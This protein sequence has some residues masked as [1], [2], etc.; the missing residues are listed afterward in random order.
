[1]KILFAL[2]V[3]EVGGVSSVARNLLNCFS[4]EEFGI[5]LLTEKLADAY[6]PI[7]SSIKLIDLNITPKKC[8][9]SKIFNMTRHII[10]IRRHIAKENPDVI[11]GFG[12]YMNCHILLSLLLHTKKRRKVILTEHSEGVFLKIRGNNI[13][14]RHIFFN[15]MYRIVM[16]FLYRRADYIVAVSNSIGFRI[17]RFFLMPSHKVKVIHN[18]VDISRINSLSGEKDS[19]LD[20]NDALPCVG[21]I[22]RLSHEKGIYFLIQGFKILLT[23][24]DAKLIIVGD[25]IERPRLE[26]LI[27]DLNIEKRVTFTG[28]V[29]NPFK[30]LA[31]MDVF[32]LPSLWEGFPNVL[33]EAMVCG[34]PVVASDSVGGIKEAVEDRINGL[35]IK[36][37][38]SIAISEAIYELLSDKEKRNRMAK[39]AYESVK[40]FDINIIKKK[41]ETLL[42]N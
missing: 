37:G 9:I 15:T 5:V 25:G 32:V 4:S 1:M 34:V 19:S 42:F 26:K 31:K 29:I 17:K 8:F 23:K 16:F 24:V 38:S 6:Y 33:L 7:D 14:I 11:L 20:F 30:Y 21:T 28:N 36:P 39:N 13:N 40:Q 41:Y 2:T 27:K 22:S 3:Y 18:P 10:S 12:A 35:L